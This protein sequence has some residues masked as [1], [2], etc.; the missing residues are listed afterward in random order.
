MTA[1]SIK[2]V[3]RTG[4]NGKTWQADTRRKQQDNP[5]VTDNSR[6]VSARLPVEIL[7]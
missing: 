5:A 2:E 3:Q 7:V 6:L 1:L 4:I